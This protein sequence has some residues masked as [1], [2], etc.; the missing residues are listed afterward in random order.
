MPSLTLLF[1]VDI[2]ASLIATCAKEKA[3]INQ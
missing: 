2:A 3:Q 1:Q